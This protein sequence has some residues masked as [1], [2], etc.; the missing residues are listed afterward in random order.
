VLVS[1]QKHLEPDE[2]AFLRDAATFHENSGLVRERM[3]PKF[4]GRMFEAELVRRQL[5]VFQRMILFGRNGKSLNKLMVI[6][7]DILM[8]GGTFKVQHDG[9]AMFA[10]LIMQTKEMKLYAKQYNDYITL[11]GTHGTNQYS[12]VMMPAT[13]VN[14]RQPKRLNVLTMD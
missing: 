12:L 8:K 3:N 2:L 1:K 7:N 9:C 6:G 10:S 11:D 4:V 13:L 5:K 14:Q